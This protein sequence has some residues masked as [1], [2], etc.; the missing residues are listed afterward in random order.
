MSKKCCGI[1]HSE[2]EKV[3]RVCGKPLNSEDVP[4][5]AVAP[6]A[7]ESDHQADKKAEIGDAEIEAVI[8]AAMEAVSGV[9]TGREETAAVQ[10][11][12]DDDGETAAAET[13]TDTRN[14]RGRKHTVN[15][16]RA[17]RGLKVMGILSIVMSVLGLAV[18]TLGVLFLVVF[19][20]YKKE[21][22]AERELRFETETASAS[23]AEPRPLLVPTDTEIAEYFNVQETA[24]RTDATPADASE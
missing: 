11:A 12:S 13:V 23:D 9:G 17:S 19:P 18:V 22:A 1:L 3:C 7:A 4:D 2:D 5:E 24:T 6:A 14:G 16:D 21:G 8:N 15:A 10:E 20:N